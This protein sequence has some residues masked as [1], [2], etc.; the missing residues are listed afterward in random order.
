MQVHAGS[1]PVIRTRLS[2]NAIR[3]RTLFLGAFRR[4][5][6]PLV[7]PWEEKSFRMRLSEGKQILESKRLKE[8]EIGK[9]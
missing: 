3:V 4:R 8:K 5:N 2:P 7:L 9:E 6:T 1:S